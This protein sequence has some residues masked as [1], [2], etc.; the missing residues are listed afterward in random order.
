[1]SILDCQVSED[2]KNLLVQIH[3]KSMLELQADDSEHG[4]LPREG[5]CRAERLRVGSST[6]R[7]LRALPR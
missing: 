1:M 7:L 2:A 4:A 6:G 5:C 3:G